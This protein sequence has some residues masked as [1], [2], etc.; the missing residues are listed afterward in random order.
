VILG[1]NKFYG[2]SKPQAEPA[3]P[4]KGRR[5]KKA[6]QSDSDDDDDGGKR[7]EWS[8]PLQMANQTMARR[9]L[10]G[11]HYNLTSFRSLISFLKPDHLS[12]DSELPGDPVTFEIDI[13]D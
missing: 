6:Q 10:R 13:A 3:V 8:K 2:L 5:A 1:K 11:E 12:A 7:P 9:S 4:A